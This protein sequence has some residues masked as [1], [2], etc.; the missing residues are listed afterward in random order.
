MDPITCIL[1]FFWNALSPS[2]EA[3]VRDAGDGGLSFLRSWLGNLLCFRKNMV[4]LGKG[5]AEL[6]S[7]R[8]RLE[9]DLSRRE[10]LGTE[11]RTA[12]V[13]HWLVTEEKLRFDIRQFESTGSAQG[14]WIPQCCGCG[15]LCSSCELGD[16][17]RQIEYLKSR[18]RELGEELVCPVEPPAVGKPR[19]TSVDRATFASRVE[20]IMDYLKNEPAGS[21]IVGIYGMCGVGKTELLTAVHS[22]LCRWSKEDAPR[23]PFQ[24]VIHVDL[25]KR[26]QLGEPDSLITDQEEIKLAIQT[27]IRNR[28]GLSQEVDLSLAIRDKRCLLL[29]DH[30][31][32]ALDWTKIGI[33]EPNPGLKVVFATVSKSVCDAMK[34]WKSVKVEYLDKDASWELFCGLMTKTKA[35]T[36]NECSPQVK[37]CARRVVSKCGGV[38]GAIIAVARGL[39]SDITARDAWDRIEQK[40]R[41]SPHEVRGM[42]DLFTTLK[43]SFDRLQR[44]PLNMADC[45]LYCSLF[46]E[47]G[48]IN[49]EQLI[50]YWIGEGFLDE[51]DGASKIDR[52]RIRGSDVIGE[53]Q[54]ACLLETGVGNQREVKLHNVVRHMALWLTHDDANKFLTSTRLDLSDVSTSVSWKKAMRISLM[55]SDNKELPHGMSEGCPQLRTLLLNNHAVDS[56]GDTRSWY[57]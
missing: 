44:T 54:Q 11:R 1:T 36:W 34:A 31:G 5:M 57:S 50:N 41:H 37:K 26:G 27:E 12:S 52:V 35:E 9:N 45:L 21:N 10:L 33:P 32:D 39:M 53:L 25:K 29:I 28:L 55:D 2:A 49:K 18:R 43:R 42:L 14:G 51:M 46:P 13:V 38:P 3:A 7:M 47:S 15:C 20:Q 6:S 22:Q 4:A 8:S 40:L 17:L 56:Y 24:K 30:V 48:G 23:L 16:L 19:S